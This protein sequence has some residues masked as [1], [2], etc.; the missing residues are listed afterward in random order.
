M[1]PPAVEVSFMLEDVVNWINSKHGKTFHPVL[2]AAIIHF[3]LVRV[4]PFITAN[5]KTAQLLTFLIMALDNYHFHH[6]ICLEEY[7]DQD[8]LQ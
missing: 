7:F 3:E 6:F 2:K 1:P 4:H 5:S 8:P